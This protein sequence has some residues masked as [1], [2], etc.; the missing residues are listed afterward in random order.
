MFVSPQSL[1]FR[2]PA[3]LF[4][5]HRYTT[6]SFKENINDT[7]YLILTGIVYPRLIVNNGVRIVKI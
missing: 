6:Q 2:N 1:R 5:K 7:R 4:F 3:Y